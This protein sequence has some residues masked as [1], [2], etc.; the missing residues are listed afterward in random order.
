MYLV[1]YNKQ[2]SWYF[3]LQHKSFCCHISEL[4]CELNYEQE[5]SQ[6]L[7]LIEGESCLS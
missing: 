1:E 5:F 4:N 3:V 6:I 2:Y 7:F